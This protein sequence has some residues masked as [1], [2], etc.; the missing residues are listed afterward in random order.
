MDEVKLAKLFHKV[1]EDLAPSYGYETRTETKEFDETSKNGKLMIATCKAILPEIK[2][3]QLNASVM[4][5]V[6]ANA[7]GK[8]EELFNEIKNISDEAYQNFKFCTDHKFEHDARF[9]SEKGKYFSRFK[10]ELR[11][12]LNIL[13]EKTI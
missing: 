5:N 6:L 7:Q 3:S 1:Y 10:I 11:D 12:I 9:W 13:E 8:T 2:A 4:P